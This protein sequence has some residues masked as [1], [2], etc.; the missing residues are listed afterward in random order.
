LTSSNQSEEELKISGSWEHP[1][2]SADS[3][4][5]ESL[6]LWAGLLPVEYWS[7]RARNDSGLHPGGQDP[8]ARVAEMETDGVS[9]EVLYP[10]HGLALYAIEDVDLQEECCHRYNEWIA[11]YCAVAPDRLFAIGMIP[12]YRMDVALRELQYCIDRGMRGSMIWQTPHPDIPLSS[13]HYEPFWDAS[14]ARSMPVSL[15]IL[16]GFNYSRALLTTATGSVP[17]SP[18]GPIGT[19]NVSAFH[20]VRQKLDC[21]VDALADLVFSGV[22]ERHPSLRAVLV[23]SE[24]SWLP[25]IVDQWDFYARGKLEHDDPQLEGRTWPSDYVRRNVAV[26]F[27][28]DPLAGKLAGSWG[29]DSWMWSND[30]PHSNSTWPNS[31]KV[32]ARQLAGLSASQVERLVWQNAARLYGVERVLPLA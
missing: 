25:F 20:S 8:Q 15:H 32:L 10:T 19:A 30:F 18:P 23:E 4:V 12:C 21:I 29:C 24:V 6:S 22:F 31:R 5:V 27:F 26:T 3:H 14:A 16:T 9:A 1:L 7:S 2:F 28:R 11:D 17:D 13:L